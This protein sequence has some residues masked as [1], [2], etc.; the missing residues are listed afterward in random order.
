MTQRNLLVYR[1]LRHRLFELI[2][3]ADNKPDLL[4]VVDLPTVYKIVKYSLR[5]PSER[6]RTTSFSTCGSFV[7]I[8]FLRKG[9]RATVENTEAPLK[10]EQKSSPSPS[11]GKARICTGDSRSTIKLFTSSLECGFN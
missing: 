5:P 2:A 1:Y 6:V 9:D 10:S 7:V 4:V 3:W 11:G 8:G